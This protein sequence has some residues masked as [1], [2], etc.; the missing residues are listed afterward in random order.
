MFV[1]EDA[2]YGGETVKLENSKMRLE[3]HKR[4]TG[5]GWGEIFNPAGQMIAV[6]DHFG[7]VKWPDLVVPVRLEA[8]EYQLDEGDFGQRLTFPVKLTSLN[9]MIK[10][11]GQRFKGVQRLRSPISEPCIEGTVTLTLEPET[12][13]LKL[14]YEFKS[15][16]SL[17]VSCIR[18]P[19]LKVG[20]G[21]FG[22]AKDDGIFPG[23]EWL[24]GEEW[25]SGTDWFIHPWALR[26]IPHPFKVG[27]PVMALSYG[28]TG[29]GLSW[30]PLTRV[31]IAD[32]STYLN[33]R[34]AQPVYASPNFIDRMN[35]HIMGLMLP[36]V[37]W[38]A[39]EN[40]LQAEPP[41]ELT[42]NG[43]IKFEAEVFLVEGNSLDVLVDWVKRHGL[44]EPPEPR[45][46][47]LDALDRIARAYNSNLWHEGQGWGGYWSISN[48]VWS[49]TS[50]TEPAFL[51]RYIDEG[52][53]RET[54]KA[55]AKKLAWVRKQPN[56][57]MSSRHTKRFSLWGPDKRLEHGRKLLSYQRE[58]GSFRFDPDYSNPDGRHKTR[59]GVAEWTVKPLGIPGDTALDL[60]VEPA[61]ELLILSDLTGEESFQEGARKALDYCMPMERPEGAD[62]WETPLHS[63]NLLAAGHAAIAYYLGYKAFNDPRYLKK[64]V[65]WIRSLLPFTHLWQPDEIPQVYN[66]KPCFCPTDYWLKNWVT[67]DVQWEVLLTFTLSADLGI[68]WGE[69]D[70][71]INWHR[72]QK[73][74]TVAALRWMIDHEETINTTFPL[75][76]VESGAMDTLWA[77]AHDC[78][79]GIYSGGPI[80]PDSIAENIYTI[81]DREGKK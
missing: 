10:S 69:I 74:I 12:P 20:A 15:L 72:Y 3:I 61:M 43:I 13:I 25:S 51:Q 68:D 22:A 32:S 17:A 55:L 66:T 19:W 75:D 36:S 71:E 57:A 48:Q 37:A 18:G 81:L 9:D 46:P 42:G 33:R 62:W 5:W 65:H 16:T 58:D 26:A 77:D 35:N 49:E 79:T 11:A 44:P 59:I 23:V 40:A 29:I 45:Y 70:P 41:L 50:P 64:A 39:K 78:T 8:Q 52:R 63:P 27:V 47:F 76:M 28:G 1:Y 21:S 6:L 80:T 56:H 53:D 60:C 34:Y 14:V 30:N 73:G 67:N 31:I 54:A 24:I 4:L 7:E 2:A 38:G